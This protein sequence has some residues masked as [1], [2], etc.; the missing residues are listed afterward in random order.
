[1]L[2]RTLLHAFLLTTLAC[3]DAPGDGD[4]GGSGSGGGSSS[5]GGDP[6][7]GAE[8]PGPA[9][10][11]ACDESDLQP[12]GWMGPAFD[13]SGALLAPLEPPYV[14]ATTVG[15]RTPENDAALEAHTTPVAMD[16]LTRDGLIGVTLAL[17]PRCNSAR[18]LSVWR[19]EAALMMFVLGKVHSAAI[20]GGLKYTLG[21]E[22]THWTETSAAAAP[23]WELAR[24]RLD[25]AR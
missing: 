19:D 17:S 3:G 6:T 25:E 5:G 21:W 7:T 14:V 1:M 20:E 2:P 15:W 4:T 16:V 13:E 10:L 12:I 24:Q 18:T 9:E 23:T 11:A 8:A 22:T